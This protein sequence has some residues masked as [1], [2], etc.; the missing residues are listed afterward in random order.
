M[1]RVLIADDQEMFR[2]G[3]RT[4]LATQAGIT[5]VGEATDGAQAVSLASR[6]LPD[7][8]LMDLRMPVK[9]GIAAIAELRE[10]GTPVKSLVLTTFE[11]ADLLSAALEAGA[12]GYILKGT[13]VDDIADVIRLVHKGYSPFSPG[14]AQQLATKTAEGQRSMDADVDG[15]T[16]R[17]REVFDLLGVGMTNR[18]IAERLHLSEGTVRNLVSAVLGHL[19]LSHRTEAALVANRLRFRLHFSGEVD[20]TTAS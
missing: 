5:V 3:L 8:I 18:Q 20:D 4:V 19:H 14:L 7:V 10:R 9:D 12:V 17:E 13:P 11:D 6:I 16:A 2:V 1:I 15:L